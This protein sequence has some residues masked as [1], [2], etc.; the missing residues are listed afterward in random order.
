M[1]LDTR[2]VTQSMRDMHHFHGSTPTTLGPEKFAT[3]NRNTVLSSYFEQAASAQHRTVE[4]AITAS[5]MCTRTHTTSQWAL[6]L[7][8]MPMKTL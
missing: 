4:C 3:K 5:D 7:Q 8:S 1:L 2:L 6:T